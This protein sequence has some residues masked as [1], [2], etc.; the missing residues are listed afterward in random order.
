MGVALANQ[1]FTQVKHIVEFKENLRV[2][3]IS[4]LFILLAA[5]LEAP[6]LEAVWGPS[7]GYLAFL[8]LIVRPAT[9][10]VSC[11]GSPLTGE[12]RFFLGWMAPRG[13]VAAAVSSIFATRLV[14]SGV[15]EAAQLVPISF[16]VI[17][18]TV[19]IYGLTASPLARRLKL[20]EPSP[21]G[22]LLVG[23][24]SWARKIAN[25]LREQGLEVALVDSRWKN[26]SAARLEGLPAHYGGIL[27]EDVLD[28]VSLF[29]I[30]RL[31][32]LTSNDE[33]NSLA[34]VHFAEIFG[35]KEVYQLPP[36]QQDG[37]KASTVQH[38][39]GRRLFS[40][41]ATFDRLQELC[42]KGA[43]VKTT[44]ITE[45]FT[46]A[47]FQERYGEDAIPL[48]MVTPGD[49]AKLAVIAADQTPKPRPGQVLVSIIPAGAAKPQT[50]VT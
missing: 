19:T 45:K 21:Q 32:A 30:G 41:K 29:G 26:V 20:A 2:L 9:V 28:Q 11:L 7:L 22:V 8:L 15:P 37:R 1:R 43:A 38:L 25:A 14:E 35:R 31:A 42:D 18:G 17:I 3:I 40:D 27:S 10:W 36:E 5:R 48:F 44:S 34:A 47:D 39:Q 46:F 33:A 23:A 50:P 4:T 13:I 49:V 12:E 6:E 24:H 16:L